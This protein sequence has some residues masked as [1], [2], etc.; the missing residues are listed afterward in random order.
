MGGQGS[1]QNIPGGGSGL[2]IWEG[3]DGGIRMA[4]YPKSERVEGVVG[5]GGSGPLR[6]WKGP[7]MSP[8]G[9]GEPREAQGQREGPCSDPRTGT[10]RL[11]GWR[12]ESG[13]RMGPV[14]GLASGNPDKWVGQRDSGGR[15]GGEGREEGRS[16][17]A[18]LWMVEPHLRWRAQ[19]GGC[20][21]GKTM[22]LMGCRA[23]EA[24]GW[25]QGI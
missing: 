5:A 14:L 17:P 7:W 2:P 24:P 15:A 11:G 3:R 20:V 18:S 4:G 10:G 6:V 12:E 22:R 16:P 21:A 9:T 23:F 1:E 13:E 8:E 19:E 25:M